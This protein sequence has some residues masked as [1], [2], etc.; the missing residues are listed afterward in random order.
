MRDHEGASASAIEIE[1]SGDR[2]VDLLVRAGE[3]TV[4]ATFWKAKAG[5]GARPPLILLQHGG[6]FHKRHER[7]DELASTLVERTGA[8]VLLI[9]GPIHGRRRADAPGV[10]AMLA[11][12][13]QHWRID[14]GIDAMVADWR[15]ALDAVLDDG[16][17]DPARV[18]WFG[19]SMGTAYGLPLCA[20]EP[21]IKVAALGLWGTD[22]GQEGHL[23]DAAR[24]MRTP[25]LFQIK[26]ADEIFSVA[27]QRELFDAIG[28]PDKCLHTFAGGHSLTAPGQLDQFVA[29]LAPALS[30]GASEG[31]C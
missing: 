27:G 10:E 26:D 8:A 7:S 15:A 23:V 25:V 14:P 9:D 11:A 21:R 22:W 1:H 17:A 31:V 3:R 24:R 20:E 2:C 16:W 30:G 29:F 19:V 5:S 6:P 28:S 12:F 18:A 13:E 4:P